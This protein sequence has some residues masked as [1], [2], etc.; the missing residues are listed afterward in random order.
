MISSMIIRDE[1][2]TIVKG[3]D[4]KRAHVWTGVGELHELREFRVKAFGIFPKRRVPDA[5]IK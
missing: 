3:K 4:L 5:R 1:A 2:T